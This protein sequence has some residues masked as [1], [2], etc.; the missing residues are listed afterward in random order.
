MSLQYQTSNHSADCAAIL[1]LSHSQE[2]GQI[3]IV[4][5]LA[6]DTH[7]VPHLATAM[8][9]I[10][11]NRHKSDLIHFYILDDGITGEQKINLNGLSYLSTFRI[12]YVDV[13]TILLQ[14]QS[15][16]TLLGRVPLSSHISIT[17]LGRLFISELI[18]HENRIIYLDCDIIVKCSLSALYLKDMKDHII[19]GTRDIASPMLAEKL[20]V[21]RY[22]NSGVLLMNLEKMRSENTINR[23]LQWTAQNIQSI[24]LGDQDI[25]NGALEN[26]IGNLSDKW[27]VQELRRKTRFSLQT[28]PA[29]I[30]YIGKHTPWKETGR[31]RPYAEEYFHYLAL[32]AFGK[33]HTEPAHYTLK[34]RLYELKQQLK[35]TLLVIISP[36]FSRERSLY[37]TYNTYRLLCFRFKKKRDF[38]SR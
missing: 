22:I 13:K 38:S 5:C 10:L 36:L 19:L 6:S 1:P 30:H 27:N 8:A 26:Y 35:K 20:G 2:E 23:I 9:S 33:H 14:N 12:D 17:S 37:E 34:Q 21:R 16:S 25:I 4:L 31:T 18:P 7:Y 32:T 15:A 29:I 24:K 3:R 28:N 11:K